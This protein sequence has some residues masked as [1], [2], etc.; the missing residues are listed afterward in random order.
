MKIGDTIIRIGK[1]EK[2]MIVSVI[3]CKIKTKE[4]KENRWYYNNKFFE[5]EILYKLTNL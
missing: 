5:E 3:V 4:F 1:I 2:T